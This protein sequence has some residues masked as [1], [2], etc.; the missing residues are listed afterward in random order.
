MKQKEKSLQLTNV[1]TYRERMFVRIYDGDLYDA[2]RKCGYT[3]KQ[4]EGLMTRK[5]I[6]D[7]IAR[8]DTIIDP[9]NDDQDII[10]RKAERMM[11]WMNSMQDN[12]VEMK[13]RLRASEL[14]GKAD[15]DF[16][17]RVQ[18][19]EHKEI[20]IRWGIEGVTDGG[21]GSCDSVFSEISSTADSQ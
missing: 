12:D 20:V 6:K 19:E 15:G 5:R 10:R 21:S 14:S 18:V 7:G 16:V 11:F 4:A 17:E 13:D 1:L 3:D 2:G 8:K 9:L